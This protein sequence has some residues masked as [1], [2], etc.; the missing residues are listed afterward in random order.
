MMHASTRTAAIHTAHHPEHYSNA[1]H[2]VT[3]HRPCIS[4]MIIII[5]SKQQNS[6]ISFQRRDKRAFS[7]N[8]TYISLPGMKSGR[9]RRIHSRMNGPYSFIDELPLCLSL[10]LS[11]TRQN[12]IRYCCSA[13]MLSTPTCTT[14]SKNK[15]NSVLTRLCLWFM[16]RYYTE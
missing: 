1:R 14:S 10:S 6:N 12:I 7:D 3:R 5:I 11:L 2:L 15:T 13:G 4:P 9:N 16:S 8:I